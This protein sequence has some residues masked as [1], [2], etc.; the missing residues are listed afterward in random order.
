MPKDQY[1]P[2]SSTSANV[3]SFLPLVYAGHPNRIQRYYQFDD[4]DRDSD[5][6]AALDTIADFCTQS[7]EQND[8]PFEVAYTTDPNESEVKIIKTMLDK[9]LKLNNMR[10]RL[11]YMFR[12]TIKNGDA[13]FLRDPETQEWLW[14]DHFMVEM[15]K[16]D[17]SAG[18]KPEE[19]LIRGLDYNRQAKFASKQADPSQYRTPFG[20]S[21]VGTTRTAS[22]PSSSPAPFSL[23]GNNSD[24]RQRHMMGPFAQDVGIVEAQHVIHMTLSIGNDVNWPFGQSILEPIFKTFKQKEL[25]EDAIIIYRV[26]RAPERRIFYIDVG[27]MPPERAKRHI[28]AIKNDIHQRRIPSRNGAGGCF[29]LATRVPLLDGRTLSIADLAI[30]HEAGKQNWAYS[31]DPAT[32]VFVPGKITWAGM[33]HRNAKVI[34]LTLDNG[35]TIICTPEHAFPILGRGKTEAKDI[36]IGVDCLFGTESSSSSLHTISARD[37]MTLPLDVGT[38]TIDGNEEYHGHH[39]FA[40]EQKVFVFNSILDAAYNPLSINDDYFFACLV[41]DTKIM[42]Y[43]G[44]CLSLL[45]IITEF[46]AKREVI[47]LARDLTT[48]K[49]EPGRVVW[50]G[51][52]RKQA[53]II[54]VT[55]TS[56][57]FVDA[58]PDHKFIARNGTEIEAANLQVGQQL[59]SIDPLYGRS[60]EALEY[61]TERYDTGDITIETASGHHVFAL[62]AGIVVHNSSADGRGSKVETLPGGQGND[63]VLDLTFFSKKLARGLRVPTSY[64]NIG[65]DDA[66]SNVAFNDGKLGAAMIQE[67]RFSKYCMRLQSLLAPV[68]DKDFKR[69][70]VK[71]GIEIEASLFELHFNPPQSFTR[72]RQIELDAQRVQVY[73]G[74]AENK[75]LSERFKLK[76]YLGLNDD[77][78]IENETMWSEENA[79]KIKAKTGTSPAEGGSQDGLGAVGLHPG[80]GMDLPPEDMPEGDLQPPD[81]SAPPGGPMGGMGGGAPPAGGGIPSAG[82]GAAPG[83]TP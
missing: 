19:Y 35:E 65:E 18:K 22:A 44:T 17:E 62:G 7:E 32:G 27:S 31:C 66:A 49:M 6:N 33:T 54:R 48:H 21:P 41:L 53:E 11:W 78:I 36:E 16:V 15:V 82:G 30:E 10:A 37:D 8:E 28:E 2:S 71:N 12:D 68:F 46:E 42:S 81:G 40:L 63:S 57:D 61:L 60:V 9:W 73:Q 14:L 39:T 50:A 13:F 64:L 4:M 59:L 79:D 75:K 3:S 70:L 43:T 25:L 51:V 72:Y 52:T 38:L 20:G 56:G 47:I 45:D 74:L 23:V 83:A 34:R 69:Y 26:Q 29:D 76:R 77:E 55:L 5:I 24:P 58:T 67:F 1:S 80:D